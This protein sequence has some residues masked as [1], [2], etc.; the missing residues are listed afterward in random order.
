MK[1]DDVD[2]VLDTRVIFFYSGD[3]PVSEFTKK[4]NFSLQSA[5]HF[6]DKGLDISYFIPEEFEKNRE[7]SIFLQQSNATKEGN[8]FFMS[9]A[10]GI[11]N[12]H[13]ALEEQL[14]KGKTMVVDNM[15]LTGGNYLL[16]CRMHSSDLS[17]FSDALLKYT[18]LL[19]GLGVSYVGSNPGMPSILK[20]IKATSS[21]KSFVWEVTVP[22]EH[23]NATF[24]PYFPN[25]WVAETRY[26]TTGAITSHLVKTEKPVE[27]PESKGINV[28]SLKENLYEMTFEQPDPF[29]NFYFKSVY[30]AR[31]LRFWR[32]LHYLDGLLKFRA[33]LPEVL[34]KHFL[35]VLSDCNNKFPDWKLT[36]TGVEDV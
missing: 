33:I 11:Q 6:T 24:Y 19:P 20:E 2:K 7:V 23:R 4:S 31:L 22:E 27:D 34:S 29:L 10:L 30:E 36:I 13:D 1:L 3:L 17:V 35:K 5:L 12:L 21:L 16:S 28:I 18:K 14:K 26:M 8:I 15:L 9:Y 32:T 25:E